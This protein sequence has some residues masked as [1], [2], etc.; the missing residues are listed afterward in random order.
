[1]RV[2]SD[3]ALQALTP[4]G[5]GWAVLAA[6]GRVV[7]RPVRDTVYNAIARRRLSLAAPRC[8]LPTAEERARFL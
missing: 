6:L 8:L 1:V 2:R 7:P 4:L 3:A 5:G